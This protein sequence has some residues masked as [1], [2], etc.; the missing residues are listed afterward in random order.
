MFTNCLDW[1]CGE[2]VLEMHFPV[3]LQSFRKIMGSRISYEISLQKWVFLSIS[4][5]IQV[6]KVMMWYFLFELQGTYQQYLAARE[7][8]KQS[9]R[10]HKKYNT[11]FQRHEEPKITTDEF[12]TGTYVYFDFHVVRDDYQQGWYVMQF[13][14]HLCTVVCSAWCN[15]EFDCWHGWWIVI[16]MGALDLEIE[17]KLDLVIH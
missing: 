14:K 16:C 7:L 2:K 4:F 10:Y 8:K 12:E 1:N 6:Q 17:D 15:C 11:W 3:W 5:D 13:F 9:W